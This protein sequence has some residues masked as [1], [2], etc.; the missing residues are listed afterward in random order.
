MRRV[1]PGFVSQPFPP[2]KGVR[3]GLSPPAAGGIFPMQ[4][5]IFTMGGTIDKVYFDDLSD[6]TVG[7]AQVRPILDGAN[8]DM[9]YEEIG[10]AHV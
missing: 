7:E 1:L 6:Y 8:V 3:G 9:E 5:A 10:R 4:L 2:V